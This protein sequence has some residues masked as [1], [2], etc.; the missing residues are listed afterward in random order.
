M[1]P[2]MKDGDIMY[3]GV[4]DTMRTGMSATNPMDICIGDNGG[5]TFLNLHFDQLNLQKG[6]VAAEADVT[7]YQCT[8]P[9]VD[10]VTL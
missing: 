8:L 6:F 3:D 4:V 1:F 9:P 2:G 7:P 10:A 5:A